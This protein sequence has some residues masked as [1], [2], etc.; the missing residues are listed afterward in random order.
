MTIKKRL[1]YRFD[2]MVICTAAAAKRQEKPEYCW[3]TKW[4]LFS[5]ISI[6]NRRASTG[7][8]IDHADQFVGFD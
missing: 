8:V 1:Q 6:F 5:G 7:L 2:S 4:F 3:K